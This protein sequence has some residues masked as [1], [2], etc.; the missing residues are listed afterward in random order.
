[1]TKTDE[2]LIS[3]I[4]LEWKTTN[5]T[6]ITSSG[7]GNTTKITVIGL[8]IITMT[9][10]EFRR[11]AH[12]NVN[13]TN[14]LICR[15]I[16]LAHGEPDKFWSNHVTLYKNMLQVDDLMEAKA[17]KILL[18]LGQS[19]VVVVGTD[20]DVIALRTL[21]V[22][23]SP[24][25]LRKQLN[26]DTLGNPWKEYYRDNPTKDARRRTLSRLNP[27]MIVSLDDTFNSSIV[28]INN[29]KQAHDCRYDVYLHLLNAIAM[30]II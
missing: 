27:S 25:V 17:R 10:K 7:N 15:F 20:E 13:P 2:P 26:P 28:N 11:Y 21:G 30:R 14:H 3:F 22:E 12:E 9:C 8:A 5:S 19:H 1:M 6:V 18:S 24:I 4:D 29:I 23:L 16:R